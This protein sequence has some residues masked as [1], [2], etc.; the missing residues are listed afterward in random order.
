MDFAPRTQFAVDPIRE[1][2]SVVRVAGELTAE[3]GPRL[4]RLLDR[5][6]DP[7]RGTVRVFVDLANV[8]AFDVE[9]V[10]ALRTARE[11]LDG[12]G[13]DMVLTGLAGHRRALPG[14]V[15]RVLDGFETAAD[16]D[17]AVAAN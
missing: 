5:A 16:L 1:G 12:T 2:K 9:G 17:D 6:A 15:G 4:L 13:V 14:R 7:A 8:W 11:R 3:T 10:E